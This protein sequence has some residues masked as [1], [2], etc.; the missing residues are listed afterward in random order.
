MNTY[1]MKGEW[2]LLGKEETHK[3]SEWGWVTR[4]EGEQSNQT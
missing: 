3:K 1:N 2:G 4:V